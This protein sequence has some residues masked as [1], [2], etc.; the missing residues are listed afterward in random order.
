MPN[1]S[2][3]APDATPKAGGAASDDPPG[4]GAGATDEQNGTQPATLADLAL[5]KAEIQELLGTQYRG[6]QSLLDRQSGSLK[7][8]LEPVN[9]LTAQLEEMGVEISPA[10]AA[11]LRNTEMM[12][13]LTGGE[14]AAGDGEP[15]PPGENPGAQQPTGAQQNPLADLAIRMMRERGVVILGED[16]E[17]ALI[18]QKTQDPKVLMDS[19][20]LA[21]DTKIQRLANPEDTGDGETEN[22]TG[23]GI[24]PRGRGKKATNLL[25]ETGPG[26]ERTTSQ[27]Y[28]SSGYEES[29]DFQ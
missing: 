24:Q 4:A 29:D 28:L 11:E 2:N 10:Q 21:I 23:P 16:A 27:D 9:R 13:S 1:Q 19:V 15:L 5:Q 18:D 6:V 12:R 14:G 17:L 7:T 26:G 3:K 25:P 8:A 22:P 20:A